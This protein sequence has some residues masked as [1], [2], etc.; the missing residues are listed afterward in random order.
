[1]ARHWGFIGGLPIVLVVATGCAAKPDV[2][3]S[4]V[5]RPA[6]ASASAYATYGLQSSLIKV[7][8]GA[9]GEVTATAQITDAPH[10]VLFQLFLDDP[11]YQ[12]TIL[13]I[14]K[15]EGTS[16]INTAGVKVIDSRKEYIAAAGKALTTIIDAAVLFSDDTPP[17]ALPFF[18]HPERLLHDNRPDSH[19]TERPGIPVEFLWGA[20]K[21]VSVEVGTIVQAK[22]GAIPNDAVAVG[23]VIALGKHDFDGLY[24]SACRDLE[25]TV[26]T[27]ARPPQGSA[28]ATKAK[29]SQFFMKVADPYFVVRQPFPQTGNITTHASCGAS[30]A[31]ETTAEQ[32]APLPG[33]VE[34]IAETTMAV[35]KALDSA[36]KAKDA[37]R[38]AEEAARKAK[39]AEKK[40]TGAAH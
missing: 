23:D 24:L 35:G 14:T 1:M 13:N 32:A 8:E 9:N 16:V 38:E 25:L 34:S 39:E 21:P 11:F 20:R 7:E 36:E 37:Q 30:T 19:G 12:T 6:D 31:D 5:I 28:A 33:L 26:L 17:L 3:Q 40:A 29:R 2:L 18:F 10:G 22:F 4:A 15:R 27:P